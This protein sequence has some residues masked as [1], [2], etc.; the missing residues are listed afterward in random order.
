MEKKCSASRSDA[1]FVSGN[2][3]LRTYL[4]HI[5]NVVEIAV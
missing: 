2:R 5:W 1:I 3:P 4:E